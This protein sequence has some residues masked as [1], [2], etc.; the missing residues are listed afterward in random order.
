[1]AGVPF[2]TLVVTRG[3]E[4]RGFDAGQ[5]E[6]ITEAVRAGVT[7]GVA[8]RNDLS[9]LEVR[10]TTERRWIRLIG[11]AILAVLI[12]PWPAELISRTMPGS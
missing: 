2:D 6:A 7:G 4:A 3:L 11:A 8:T 10:I 9:R 5:V 12:L 1:M